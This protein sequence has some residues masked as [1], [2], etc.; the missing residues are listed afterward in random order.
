MFSSRQQVPFLSHVK[1]DMYRYFACVFTRLRF[2]EINITIL[3][4]H[5]FDVKAI[6]R[7]SQNWNEILPLFFCFHK[8]IVWEMANNYKQIIRVYSTAIAYHSRKLVK[9]NYFGQ[10]TTLFMDT[11]G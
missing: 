11:G 9:I 1:S 5:P 2:V 4:A 3:Y 6:A 10:T 7:S 8:Y